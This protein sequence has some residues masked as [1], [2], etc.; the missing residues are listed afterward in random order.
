MY[1]AIFEYHFTDTGRLTITDGFTATSSATGVSA[2]VE[3][4]R[5]DLTSVDQAFVV[6]NGPAVHDAVFVATLIEGG[7][8]KRGPGTLRDQTKVGNVDVAI[9]VEG[10]V[11]HFLNDQDATDVT[12]RAGGRLVGEAK[13][14]SLTVE[15]GGRVRPGPAT[16]PGTLYVEQEL[17]LLPSA[18]VE[19]TLNGSVAGSGHTQIDVDGAVSLGGAVL[20]A[21][22]GPNVSVGQQFRIINN[23][24]SDTITGQFFVPPAT[25]PFQL[26]SPTGQRLSFNYVG[27]VLNNDLVLTLDNTPPMAPNLAL[28]ATVINEGDTVL[29]TGNLVD[30][31]RRDR[32]RL[33]VNWG[34][35]SP[36]QT[37]LPGTRP[38]TLRHRYRDD[39]QYVARFEWLDQHSAGN[40]RSFTITVN[41]VAPHVA[42]RSFRSTL[43]DLYFA[44]GTFADPGRDR[45]TATV[46]YG[47]GAGAQS[48]VLGRGAFWLWHRF[49]TPGD[50]TVRV[51]VRDEDGGVTTLERL[52]TV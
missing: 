10:G 45:L 49:R 43:T 8:V 36:Q 12:V 2:R 38:F 15:A 46:D 40:S 20:E 51:D 17:V 39:G 48:L 50:Y 3:H 13:I 19:V 31:D 26:A 11:V 22:L 23:N 25:A 27:G 41:N 44:L 32:L 42:V 37:F 16:G 14:R 21:T 1:D 47:D 6:N 52:F 29:V 18:I 28:S 9:A 35:G 7:Y 5:L 33:L 34:D 24:L 30:P 4:S